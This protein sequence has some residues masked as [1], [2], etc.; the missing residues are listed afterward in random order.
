MIRL[1]K[2]L[3]SRGTPDFEGILKAEIEQLGAEQLPLQQGLSTSSYALD[4]K[5]NVR[6]ISVSE[7]ARFIRAKVGIFYA[8]ITPGCSCAD[9]PTPVEE[10]N[11]YCVVQLDIDKTTAETTVAL[12]EE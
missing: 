12:L 6:I 8:G 3:N 2:S 7:E 1:T 4:D 9:D 11:E 10:Q 5:L